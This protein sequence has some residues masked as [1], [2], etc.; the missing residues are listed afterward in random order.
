MLYRCQ[1]KTGYDTLIQNVS[2]KEIT[3]LMSATLV[4]LDIE[5]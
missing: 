1:S 4:A 2:L 3:K 5:L